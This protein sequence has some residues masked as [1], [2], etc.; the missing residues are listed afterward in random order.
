MSLKLLVVDDE[1]D[2]ELLIRQKF[3]KKIQQQEMKFVFA[4]N[5]IEALKIIEQEPDVEI[6][7]TDI[8][9]PEMDGLT[10]LGKLS[11]SN[12]RPLLKAIVV[13]AYGDMENIRTAMNR[14]AF[15]FITKPIDFT[16]LEITL[17]KTTNHIDTLK[18]ALSAREQLYAIHQELNIARRIQQ[19]IIP[20]VFPPF[21][22]RKDFDV[23]ASMT[24]AKEVG[25]DFY[26]FFLI[27]DRHF[28]FVV[29]DVSG[30]GV[31]AAIFMA[32]SRTLLKSTAIKG[33]SPGECLT[34]TNKILSSESETAMF[35]TVFY[36][37]LD[38]VTGEMTYSNGGHN[39][40]YILRAGGV[41]EEIGITGGIVV[42]IMGG[43]TYEQAS[44]KLNPGDSIFIFTDGVTEAMDIQ[45]EM[46][47]DERLKEF[48][49]KQSDST[50]ESLVKN[51]VTDVQTYVNGAPQSDDITAL[52]VRYNGI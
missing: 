26:D 16:D 48:L 51:V 35:V 47:S 49:E 18:Q 41:V 12:N 44:L 20:Q 8:N 2:L 34:H 52:S 5:G 22:G 43:F 1:P 28:G 11:E 40:P 14:G 36:G 15:D 50:V 38:T 7:M 9:M 42:G 27:D 19:A 39:P 6:V 10:F 46:Y 17:A 3:R 25:G 21:P 30:K 4:Q 23:F 33:V 45:D 32:M 31:P 13:S 24:P 37:V 29:G